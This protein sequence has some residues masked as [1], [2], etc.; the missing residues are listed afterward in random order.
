MDYDSLV[1]NITFDGGEV[2]KIFTVNITNDFIPE[3]E[4]LFEVFLKTI[5]GNLAV[6]I[7]EPS[8]ATGTILDDEVPSKMCL[9]LCS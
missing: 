3:S 2:S 6:V 4:E 5:P 9:L 1:L 8:V 7:G